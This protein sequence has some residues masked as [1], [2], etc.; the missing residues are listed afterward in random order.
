MAI[1]TGKAKEFNTPNAGIKQNLESVIILDLEQF[2][3][4]YTGRRCLKRIM[5]G[6]NTNYHNLVRCSCS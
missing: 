1:S 6:R 4:R 3:Y 5:R 2:A